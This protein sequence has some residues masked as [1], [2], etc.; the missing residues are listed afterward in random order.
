MVLQL[1]LLQQIGMLILG[2]IIQVLNKTC[3]SSY[4]LCIVQS[5]N[6]SPFPAPSKTV[7]IVYNENFNCNIIELLGGGCQH[8]Q[9]Q[10]IYIDK[11][12]TKNIKNIIVSFIYDRKC[13]HNH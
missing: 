6:V 7:L 9:T 10:V 1:P 12:I 3:S 5:Y 2:L 11:I 8:W 4:C 13:M